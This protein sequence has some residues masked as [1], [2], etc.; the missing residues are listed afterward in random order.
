MLKKP[1]LLMTLLA[2]IHF[3]CKKES[4][5]I[6]GMVKDYTGLDG[7]GLVIVLDDG[8]NLEPAILPQNI[9][10]VADNRIAIKYRVLTDRVSNCMVGTI[11]QILALRYL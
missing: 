7:C 11:V 10:L 5:E 6:Q 3:S 8:T 2:C 4:A 1:L 9:S